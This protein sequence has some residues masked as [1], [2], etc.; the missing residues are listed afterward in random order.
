[1]KKLV[2]VLTVIFIL[3]GLFVGCTPK[4]QPATFTP[5]AEYTMQLNVGPTYDWGKGA[6]KWADLIKEKTG[7][8]II[9]K[10]YFSSSLLAGKQTNWF[11]AVAEGSID[12]ATESTINASATVKSLNLFS[13]PFFFNG[14]E[15]VDKIENGETGKKLFKEMEDM[16]VVC[17]A[18]GEN[19][20]REITNSKKSITKPEDMK[21][22]KFRVV[23]SPIFIDIFHALGAD[24]V[25][26]N[27]G[28]AVTAFQ[29]GAVDGQENPYGVLLPTKIWEYHKYVTNW[30][31]LLD[32]LIFCV[33]KKTWDTFPDDIKQAITEAALE[34][35]EWNKA[36]SRR[37][38][39]GTTSIDILKQKF[40]ET[41]E[42]LDQVA[43]VKQM[44]MTVTELT[45]DEKQAFRDA[46]KAVFDKWV[47]TVGE[48]LVNLAKKDMGR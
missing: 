28:D 12:F 27:W 9:V 21:G 11:Q 48:A 8:K 19:G 41:P 32:P 1:M 45:S 23:G 6:Q 22:L 25:S 24:A 14:Y 39:D 17:L 3:T 44:G 46:T 43:Y 13:L 37:G 29:Q 15:D 16:G 7:G 4:E 33:S 26:M 2:S 40:N 34:A 47:P 5:K 10:P 35:G 42:I 30:H 18:W 31:Y 36:Y 20:F 38:L